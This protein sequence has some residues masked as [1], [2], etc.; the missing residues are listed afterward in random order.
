VSQK[1]SHPAQAKDLYIS[2]LFELNLKYAKTLK[3]DDIFVLS[4]KHGLL[5][6]EKE[7]EPYEQT[8]N[9]MRTSEIKHWANGVL[10]QIN[11]ICSIDETEF[12]FLAGEKYR[13][14][15]LPHLKTTQIPLEGLR[16]GKQ[17]QK[18]KELTG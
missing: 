5:P 12:I 8:L 17:L 4:A 2:T 3:P 15:L 6:L 16:I 7:I 11:E 9:N 14:Y 1:A 10:E 13:K 18:L